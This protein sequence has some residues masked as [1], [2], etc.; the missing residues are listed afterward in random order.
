MK[1]NK[2][3]FN[4]ITI[5]ILSLFLITSACKTKKEIIDIKDDK[6]TE[7]VVDKVDPNIAKSKATLQKMIDNYDDY[8]IEDK[9][10]SI[11]KIKTLNLNDD[12]IDGMITT[13]ETKIAEEKEKIRKEKE[14][15][16]KPENRLKKYFNNIATASNSTDA[17]YNIKETL[18][19]FKT[20]T[21]TVLIIISEGDYGKDYD[22]PTNITKYLNQ[23]KDTKNNINAVEEIKYDDNNKIKTLILRKK[24]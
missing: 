2:F 16:A 4:I 1:T 10:A 21:A 5:L 7:E 6:E 22:K 17:D 20:T 3:N 23:L 24:K 8:S 15:A 11:A 14:D 19:M 18:K 13:L 9:E 12:E